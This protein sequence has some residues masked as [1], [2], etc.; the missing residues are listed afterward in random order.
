[1]VDENA[2]AADP[3][4]AR[5]LEILRNHEGPAT[6]A[7]IRVAAGMTVGQLRP[8]LDQMVDAG[9]I[10][11]SRRSGARGTPAQWEPIPT[12]HDTPAPDSTAPT[13]PPAGSDTQGDGDPPVITE[14]GGAS[15]SSPEPVTAPDLETVP[16]PDAAPDSSTATVDHAQAADADGKA[17]QPEAIEE[18]TAPVQAGDPGEDPA[19]PADP[20]D[21]VGTATAQED[22]T[23]EGGVGAVQ[24]PPATPPTDAEADS[25]PEPDTETAPDIPSAD[26][27]VQNPSVDPG[28]DLGA[29]TPM[30]A[31][32][33]P[34]RRSVPGADRAALPAPPVDAMPDAGTA[35]GDGLT[36]PAPTPA[37][38]GRG[39]PAGGVECAA[40]SCPASHCP[41][42]AGVAPPP[43]P[44]RRR[45]PKAPAP[46]AGRTVNTD[47]KP[48]L[49]A[50]ALA[51]MV[52]D[53]LAA[54]ADVAMSVTEISRE[55]PGRSSGAINAAGL[56]MTRRGELTLLPGRPKRFQITPTG[57]ALTSAAAAATGG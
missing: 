13:E 18:D 43:R 7:E 29:V 50:G 19:D 11:A 10:V 48:R 25:G 26:P 24:E 17:E 51:A 14:A 42:R 3:D 22:P 1:M 2:S 20:A 34:A 8:V 44:V 30:E 12:P 39:V 56:A 9:L 38:A 57:L 49:Q 41:V 27:P 31:V 28:E 36:H 52:L 47:G 15:D 5:V 46:A 37:S 45:A 16:P 32:S 6:L 40:W 55:I 53:V 33:E 35:P 23:A 54:H 4:T 21:P